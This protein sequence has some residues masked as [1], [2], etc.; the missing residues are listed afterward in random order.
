MTPTQRSLKALRAAG[1]TAFPVENWN[2]F[3][4]V[5]Q[6]LLGIGDILALKA[7]ETLL[8]QCTTADHVSHRLARIRALP[9]A[10][11]WLA[12]PT[13]QI[14]IHGWRK[15]GARGEAK[16]WTCREVAVRAEDFKNAKP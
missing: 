13:R 6:D 5:K 3:A 2:A 16:R 8:I 14:V 12:C 11:A 15:G 10:R 7:G 4:R 1:W 9:A